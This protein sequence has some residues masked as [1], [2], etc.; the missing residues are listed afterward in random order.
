MWC[1][2]LSMTCA[3][4]INVNEVF[5]DEA[6]DV[7]ISCVTMFACGGIMFV[8]LLCAF[9]SLENSRE[10]YELEGKFD[11]KLPSWV[12][13]QDRDDTENEENGSDQDH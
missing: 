2:A 11:I 13:R 3:L 7:S 6:G 9:L 4:A 12:N 8:I 1:G 5:P 10:E